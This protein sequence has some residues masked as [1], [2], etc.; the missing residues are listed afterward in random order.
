MHDHRQ[1]ED[2]SIKA[3]AKQKQEPAKSESLKKIILPSLV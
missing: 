2:D 3:Q 1:E